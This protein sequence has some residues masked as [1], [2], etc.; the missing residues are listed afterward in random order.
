MPN[1]YDYKALKDGAIAK[2]LPRYMYEPIDEPLYPESAWERLPDYYTAHVAER[3]ATVQKLLS[4]QDGCE[5]FVFFSDAHV[6]QN[7]MSS[8]PILRSIL[9]NTGVKTVFYGG[10]T[11]SAWADDGSLV[12]DINYF[13][14]AFSFAKPYMV[15]GNHDMYGK[16]FEYANTGAVKSNRELYELIFR[17]GAE[18]VVGEEGKTYYYFDHPDTATRYIII[19]TNEILTPYHDEKGVWNCDV[20]ISSTEIEWFLSLLNRTPA[21]WGVVVLGHT[22]FYREL[23]WAFPKACIFGDLIEAYNQR[24]CFSAMSWDGADSFPV[25]ADFTAAQGEVLLTVCG[26]GHIDDTYISPSGCVNF[27]IHCDAVLTDN[28]GSP[29]ARVPGTVSENVLDVMII[30]RHSGKIHAVRYGAGV[31]REVKPWR[32]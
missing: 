10:D 28:G 19:D 2:G 32:A 22:P 8:V 25:K 30:N 26:H 17:V 23:R 11:V 18:R 14:H 13:A 29:F 20:S 31:D 27:E 15:R 5:A 1:L 16:L 6:R 9:Q 7:R 4:E 12:E 3:N 24:K 21:N